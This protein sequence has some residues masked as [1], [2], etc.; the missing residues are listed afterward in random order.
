MSDYY[1]DDEP[2]QS[3]DTYEEEQVPPQRQRTNAEWGALRKE[4][5]AR[6]KAEAERDEMKR[7]LAFIQAG[8]DPNDE[9]SGYFVR[10]YNGE[11][12]PQAIKAAA[13]RIGFVDSEARQPVEQQQALAA[14][15]RI[16]NV[17]SSPTAVQQG[18]EAQQ[19]ALAE[20]FAQGGTPAVLAKMSEMG[21]N[22]HST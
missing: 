21:I 4:K 18:T 17:A 14:G 3:Q 5:R 11:M 9:R 10:G 16:S 22:I 15:A 1:E 6:T 19:A 20:A 7:T 8:I 12:T 13:L 2:E